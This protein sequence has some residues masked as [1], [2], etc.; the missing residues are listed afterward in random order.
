MVEIT[1]HEPIEAAAVLLDTDVAERF[2]IDGFRGLRR[3]ELKAFARPFFI[4]ED[5]Q[6]GTIEP[7]RDDLPKEKIIPM[8]DMYLSQGK[9][10]A[11]PFNL[12]PQDAMA[13]MQKQI[14]ELQAKLAGPQANPENE[15]Y[16]PPPPPPPPKPSG[17]PNPPVIQEAETGTVAL[18]DMKWQELCTYARAKGIDPWK[19]SRAVVTALIETAEAE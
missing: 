4:S 17:D 5:N 16:K 18:E 8:L 11:D 19:K 13:A 6:N 2:N 14:A 7:F 3:S 9:F 1:R 15:L 12:R 10:G